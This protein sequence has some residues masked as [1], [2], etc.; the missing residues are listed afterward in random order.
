MSTLTFTDILKEEVAVLQAQYPDLADGLS[1]AQ[2]ERWHTLCPD[3]RK[4][5]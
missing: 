3:C 2:A 1:P 5:L 4:R